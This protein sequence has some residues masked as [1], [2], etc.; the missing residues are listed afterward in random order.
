MY[1]IV[2]LLDRKDGLTH[3]AFLDAWLEDH[4][5]DAAGIPGLVRYT[6]CVPVEGDDAPYDGITELYFEDRAA[7]EAALDS[8]R[9][10]S[11][12]EDARTFLARS[13]PTSTVVEERVVYEDLP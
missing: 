7:A 5:S 9:K 13:P 8:T 2:M 11:A 10:E 4:A 1:K 12:A 6:H 3:E